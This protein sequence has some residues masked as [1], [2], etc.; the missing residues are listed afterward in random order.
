MQLQ[1]STLLLW[2]VSAWTHLERLATDKQA[3]I[4]TGSYVIYTGGWAI[5]VCFFHLFHRYQGKGEVFHSIQG[6][7]DEPAICLRDGRSTCQATRQGDYLDQCGGVKMSA[8]SW[9]YKNCCVSFFGNNEYASLM[10][11]LVMVA[12]FL[13]MCMA[14][15]RK[16]IFIKL[17][18]ADG[19]YRTDI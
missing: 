2:C 4:L 11:A 15:Y 17:L 1:N 19:I 13:V 8:L 16:K 5:V 7:G 12:I 3:F 18:T 6:N 14:L 10:H 9:F